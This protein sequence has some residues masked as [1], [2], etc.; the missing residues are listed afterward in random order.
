V[1][2]FH[3]FHDHQRIDSLHCRVGCEILVS[4]RFV[5]RHRSELESHDIVAMPG[6]IFAIEHLRQIEH[7]PPESCMSVRRIPLQSDQGDDG[8]SL[9]ENVG[10]DDRY[11]GDDGTVTPQ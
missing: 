9:T 2:A 4:Q 11:V 6:D 8:Q 7:R 5:L 1:T 10:I 3:G